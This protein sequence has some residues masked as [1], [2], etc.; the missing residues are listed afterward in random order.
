MKWIET[1]TT[2]AKEVATSLSVTLEM[3]FLGKSTD[4]LS[5]LEKII[6]N[7]YSKNLVSEFPKLS[8]AKVRSFWAKL[9]RMLLSRAQYRNRKQNSVDEDDGVLQGL[10]KLLDKSSRQGWALFSK[11][12]DIAFIGDGDVTMKALNEFDKWKGN[13]AQSYF[14]GALKDY[15]EMLQG[16]PYDRPCCHLHFQNGRYEEILENIKCPECHRNLGKYTAFLCHHGFPVGYGVSGS[17]PSLLLPKLLPKLSIYNSRDQ[18][19]I[20]LRNID[21]LFHSLI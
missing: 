21:F 3:F 19:K 15:C 8:G 14:E 11:G 5:K 13:V 17:T 4:S 12:D 16:G 20:A 6:S 2:K 10:E 1:F 18:E 7:I 9:E